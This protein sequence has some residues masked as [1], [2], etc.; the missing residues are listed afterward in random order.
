MNLSRA[1]STLT[2]HLLHR[3]KLHLALDGQTNTGIKAADYTP[4]NK[5]APLDPPPRPDP[6]GEM[7]IV[8]DRARQ[9]R[10]ELVMAELRIASAIRTIHPTHQQ[11]ATRTALLGAIALCR[12][13]PSNPVQHRARHQID[14]AAQTI[15]RI[16]TE[17]MGHRAPKPADLI[18][19]AH[20][21]D[22]GCQSCAR[23]KGW[24]NEPT[25]NTRKPGTL[26]GRL[27]DA[28]LLCDPCYRF[29][30]VEDRPPTIKELAYRQTDP[31][32]H[33]P[34]RYGKAA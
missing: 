11:P 21:G 16:T 3:G 4:S 17:V 24:W 33:W 15:H 18:H 27:P 12:S 29:T 32:G 14:N 31:R 20:D 23:H 13:R 2:L 25:R 28:W 1:A 5:P 9:L 22:P 30:L 19:L 34:K 7:A 6:C 10:H 8:S 26:D